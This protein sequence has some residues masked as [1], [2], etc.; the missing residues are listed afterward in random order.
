LVR[1][2]PQVGAAVAER[3]TVGVG[4]DGLARHPFS[5]AKRARRMKLMH[6]FRCDVDHKFQVLVQSGSP[7]LVTGMSVLLRVL[8]MVGIAAML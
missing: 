3:K 6:K 8:S 7:G 1:R 5:R 2:D 4:M